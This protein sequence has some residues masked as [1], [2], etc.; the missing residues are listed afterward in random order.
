M[1]LLMQR[2]TLVGV[3]ALSLVACNNVSKV[4]EKSPS[5]AFKDYKNEVTAVIGVG[6]PISERQMK[7]NATMKMDGTYSLESV[8]RQVAGTYNVAVRWDNGVRKNIRRKVLVSDLTFDEVRSYLEDVYEIQIV[9]EGERRLLVLPSA[10]EPRI[11]E[12]APGINVRLSQAVR[13]LAKECGMNL[14]IS[15]NKS[16][17]ADTLVT[18]SL[19][20]VTCRDAMSALLVPH[21]LSLI[22]AG[23]YFTVGG[24]PTR[25]WTLD[26]YEMNT[27]ETKKIGYVSEFSGS[28]EDTASSGGEVSIEIEDQRDIWAELEEN[29]SALV[30]KSCNEAEQHAESTQDY[31]VLSPP[32]TSGFMAEPPEE[33]RSGSEGGSFVCGYVRVNRSVGLVQM[34]APVPVLEQADEIIQRVQDIASRRLVVE[35]RVIAVTKARGFQQGAKFSGAVESDNNRNLLQFGVSTELDDSLDTTN[36]SAKLVEL[37]SDNGAGF[38]SL[39]GSGLDLVARLAEQFGTTYQLMSPTIEVMDRQRAVLVDGRNEKYFVLET[40]VETTDAGS[41][42]TTTAEERTQFVG[43]Q[44]SVAAQIADGDKP[45]TV[46]VQVP[47]LEISRFVTVPDGSN[48]QVPVVTSRIIDQKVR[49]RDGEIKVIGG[50]NRTIAVDRE[51]GVPLLRGVPVAGKLFNEEDISYEDVEF[52]VLL[53]VRRVY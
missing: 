3:L 47:M 24:Y 25:E 14:V 12:F 42:T 38:V 46:S 27:R 33:T 19:R 28:G 32:G 34:R 50:L 9:R 4:Q 7:A 13:G 30:E 15:E 16:I 39:Q 10:N 40:N 36:I 22:D 11:K 2:S 23:D 5:N 41:V 26:L 49:I 43:L 44:F 1:I 48:S 8:I 20:D 35:A 31:G 29:L 18:T 17:L 21:G 45:H 6:D 52:I 51:S 37:I 53:Q